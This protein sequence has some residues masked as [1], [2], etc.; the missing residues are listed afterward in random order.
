VAATSRQ[1][2]EKQERVVEAV[3]RGLEGPAAVE[4]IHHAGYAITQPGIARHLR[5]MGG[6][7]K[8]QEMIGEGKS[9]REI[10]EASFPDEDIDL[11]GPAPRQPELFA[12]EAGQPAPPEPSEAHAAVYDTVKMTVRM[13]ADLHEAIKIAAKVEGK[14]QNDLIVDIL[15]HHLSQIPDFEPGEGPREGRG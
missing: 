15:T 14:A 3:R 4:F 9:N 8:V 2:R 7:G 10:L 11:P 13:P 5:S 12:T 6:R 1:T